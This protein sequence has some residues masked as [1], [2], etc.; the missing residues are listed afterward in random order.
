MRSAARV[1]PSEPQPIE[2]GDPGEGRTVNYDAFRQMPERN[3][4]RLSLAVPL[5]V[6]LVAADLIAAAVLRIAGLR[7]REVKVADPPSFRQVVVDAAVGEEQVVAG[8]VIDGRERVVLDRAGVQALESL[9]LPDGSG[10]RLRRHYLRT[11]LDRPSCRRP[12]WVGKR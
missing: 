2:A 5:E 6:D 1:L 4:A 7:L 3:R 12:G 10:A 9:T 11:W 8:P